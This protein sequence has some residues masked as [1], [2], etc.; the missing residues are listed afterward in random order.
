LSNA[1]CLSEGVDV[2][3]LDGVAFIDPRSSQVD[4]IQAVGRAI[5]LSAD[6]KAGTI[7]LPVFIRVSDDAVGAIEASNFKPVWEVLNALKAH[8]DVLACELDQMRTAMGREGGA[9]AKNATFGKIAFDLPVTV[10]AGLSSS[11][12][13]YLV[14][15]VTAS[16]YHWYGLLEEYAI[17]EGNAKVPLDFRTTG[18]YRLGQW[19]AQQRTKSNLLTED[20]RQRLESLPGWSWDP[21]SDQWEEGFQ[22]LKEFTERDGHAIVAAAYKTEEGFRLGGWLSTQRLKQNSMSQERK[23]M[24][25]ALPGWTWDPLTDQWEEGF[26]YLEEFV[27]REGHANVPQFEKTG[28]GFRI[29]N[30]VGTQRYKKN[31]LLPGR[32][33]RLEALPG[34]TWDPLSERWEEGFRYLKEFVEREGNTKVSQKHIAPDGYRLGQWVAVQRNNADGISAERRARMEALKGWSWDPLSD[35]CEEGFRHLTEFVGRE[36]HARV[37]ASYKTEDGYLLGAWVAKQRATRDIASEETKSRLNGLPGWTWDPLTE[38]W[39]KGFR[40]LQEFVEREGHAKAVAGYELPNGFKLGVWVNTQRRSIELLTT[41][42]KSRLEE[43]PGWSWDP[44]SDQWEEGFRCLKEFVEREGDAKVPSGCKTINDFKLGAW[45]TSQRKRKDSLTLDYRTRLEALPGWS[46]N[47][48]S[49]RWETGFNFARE[50]VEREGHAR[51][52]AGYV[53]S[54]GYRL[55]VYVSNQRAKKGSISTERKARLEGLPGWSWDALLSGW[56]EGY[57]HLEKFV[58]FEGHARVSSSYKSED[59]YLLGNWVA[60]Q[61][62][63]YVGMPV[64]KRNLLEALPGWTWD[65][66][67]ERWEEGFRYLKEFVELEG[68]A[69][70]SVSFTTSDGYRLGIWVRNQRHSRD[71]LS[72]ERIARLEALP[73]WCWSLK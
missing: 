16:W 58:E 62:S 28:D 5:R 2:P 25:E 31:Q 37:P 32:K 63:S 61:R 29:G 1:R 59:G 44:F 26:R 71:K 55:G 19:V 68:Y 9:S 4:I 20:R 65:P 6:K 73:G 66:L 57:L 33:A 35:R 38:K 49:D 56:E 7:I 70:V 34:W 45:V 13:T 22:Y 60:K 52:P 27:G 14:E 18:G 69:R 47:T 30:W 64:E 50:F 72:A 11:L 24:L 41:D 17:R 36:G 21:F 23:A 46:W 53:T 39:E 3:A 51:I 15:Q 48:L 54:C 8:D 42:K 40:H 67:S 43:L 10:D 12:R